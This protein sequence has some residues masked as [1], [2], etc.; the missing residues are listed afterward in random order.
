LEDDV[1]DVETISLNLSN[2][3][4]AVLSNTCGTGVI[5]NDDPRRGTV[6]SMQ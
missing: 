6:R 3:R 2:P 4:E 1:E 5:G